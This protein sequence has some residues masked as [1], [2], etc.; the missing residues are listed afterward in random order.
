M[1]ERGIDSGPRYTAL[2]VGDGCLADV[3]QRVLA[4]VELLAVN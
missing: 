4:Q 1:Q 2:A 3:G